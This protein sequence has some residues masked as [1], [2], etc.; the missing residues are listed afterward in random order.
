VN[1]LLDWPMA[2]TAGFAVFQDPEVNKMVRDSGSLGGLVS[3]VV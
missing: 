1:A 3:R 2:T